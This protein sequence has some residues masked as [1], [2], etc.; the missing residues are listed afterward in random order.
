MGVS[1]Y[2]ICDTDTPDGWKPADGRFQTKSFFSTATTYRI[3]A[4]GRL[5]ESVI[6]GEEDVPES[7]WKFKD[8]EP[9]T[10]QAFFHEHSKKRFIFAEVERPWHGYIFFYGGEDIADPVGPFLKDEDQHRYYLTHDYRAKFT[11]GRLVEIILAPT[12]AWPPW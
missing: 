8:A 4:D 10:F 2:L 7:E 12:D 1:D 11:D 3:T 6:V 5:M 9:G